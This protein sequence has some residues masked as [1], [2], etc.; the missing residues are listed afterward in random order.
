MGFPIILDVSKDLGNSLVPGESGSL[1]ISFTAKFNTAGTVPA[2]GTSDM[3]CVM[4]LVVDGQLNISPDQCQVQLGLTDQ[5][6]ESAV[7][8]EGKE[9]VVAE[10]DLTSATAIAGAGWNRHGHGGKLSVKGIFR[11]GKRLLGMTARSAPMLAML[12]PALAPLAMGATL[13]NA[14][15]NGPSNDRERQLLE[16]Q[17]NFAAAQQER[18]YDQLAAQQQAKMDALT[19][20]N[21]VGQG[22]VKGGSRGR[23]RLLGR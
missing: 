17:R 1:N 13:G 5:D 21:A 22:M 11:F 20:S 23:A 7:M 19:Q 8:D 18:M 6:I 14:M 10:P 4:V 15:I 9:M 2:A 3:D 12:N 16:N